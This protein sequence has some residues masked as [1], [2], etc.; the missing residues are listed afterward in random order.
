MFLSVLVAVLLVSSGTLA[1][2][3]NA[4]NGFVLLG[5]FVAGLFF[6]SVFT[7]APA[8][9]ALGVISQAGGIL[10]TAFLGAAGAVIGDLIIFRFVKDRFADDIMALLAEEGL[11]RRAKAL[12]R[13]KTFRWSLAFLGGLII[14]S[15]LP[16]ELGVT[17]L[18]FSKIKTSFFIPISY[19]FN[20]LGVLLIGMVA[21]GL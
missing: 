6:T 19:V 9:A 1:A 3:L 11:T 10:P 15:P 21:R 12:F 16:D 14:A 20:F 13:I 17:L 2:L 5:A 7:T 18:G 4:T 8:I